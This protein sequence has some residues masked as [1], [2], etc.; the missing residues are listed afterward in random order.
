M[1]KTKKKVKNIRTKEKRGKVE[2]GREEEIY[3]KTRETEGKR[4][5]PLAQEPSESLSASENPSTT[6]NISH[7]KGSMFLSI[8][9]VLLKKQ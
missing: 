6:N 7:S 1:H 8:T 2:D 9:D 5:E 4:Q 3:R